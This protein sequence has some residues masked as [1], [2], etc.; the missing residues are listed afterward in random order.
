M[1]KQSKKFKIMK[2]SSPII[3]GSGD[4]KLVRKTTADYF[5]KP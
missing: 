5:T 1:I 2:E 3:Y 4:P